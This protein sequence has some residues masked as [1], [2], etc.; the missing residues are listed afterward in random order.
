MKKILLITALAAFGSAALAAP[1]T[2]ST[3]QGKLQGQS[4]HGVN[5]FKGIPFA[6]PPIGERRWKPAEPAPKWQGVRLA[7]QYGPNCIQVPYPEGSFFSRPAFPTSE[8]CLYLNVW[9][10][11]NLD[12]G[13]SAEK[14]PVMVW[15][16][17]G[18]LTRGGGSV[19]VYDGSNLTRKG[20]VVVTINYR[21]GPLGYFSH[22]ELTAESP[23]KASGNQGTTDQIQALK[24]VQENI[25]AFGG[26]PD[27]V[28]IFGESA[29]SWSVNHLVAS[30]LA[31]DLFHGAIGQSGA[32]LSPMPQLKTDV[33]G[34]ASAE[35][36]GKQFAAEALGS[37]KAG[38]AA[39]RALPAHAIMAVAEASGFRTQGIVDGWVF[40]DQIYNI[41]A[42][43]KQNPVPVIVG[44]N[45][46]E[47]TTL[48]AAA[49][50]PASKEA[51][52]K[53]VKQRYGGYAD[54]Y[55]Q[56][57]PADDLRQSTLDAFRDS[58]VSWSM[59]TWAMMTAN[60][61]QP[62]WLYY[63]SHR[64]SGPMKEKLGAYHAAEIQYVFDNYREDIPHEQ[65][66][67]EIMSDYWVAFAKTGNP[68][69]A[70]RPEWK[71]YTR[72]NRHYVEFNTETK[73][74]V[75]QGDNLLPGVWEFYDKLN[76]S[77]RP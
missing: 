21:L 60:V 15:I 38:L 69:E 12:D 2:I 62:A 44:F 51:Y 77:N 57:Y 34:Q 10:P 55:L 48:G 33:A 31:K 39:L 22:P 3:P 71:P 24:W 76:A 8:D 42:E 14:L 36:M 37:K 65:E 13:K 45:S 30:P 26:D 72:E 19:D 70:D 67:A 73:K 58:F 43:G 35:S 46:D 61:D 11:A 4:E 63:F 54:E 41:M 29:G 75:V 50:L 40:P 9:T 18:A 66:M 53:G 16:H 23:H 1:V 64:P 68:N 52:I 7:E 6:L 32:V 20:V 59:P 49:R 28:T 17:G 27:Q 47:G 74:G 25:A 56:L 5:A